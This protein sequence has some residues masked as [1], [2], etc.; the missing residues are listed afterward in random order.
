METGFSTNAFVKN[1][2]TFAINSVAKTGFDGIEIVLDMPHAFL[3]MSKSRFENIKKN[4]KKNKLKITNLNANTVEGEIFV[5]LPVFQ[6]G[7]TIQG[8]YLKFE[9][10][11]ITNYTAKKAKSVKRAADMVKHFV[12]KHD[13]KKKTYTN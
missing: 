12:L 5:D 13:P 1:S 3:P 8:I 10:G 6:G 9:N 11:V 7:T 2:L 4:V